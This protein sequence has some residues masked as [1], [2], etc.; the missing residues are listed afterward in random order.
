MARRERMERERERGRERDHQVN[1]NSF[2]AFW[3]LEESK[4]HGQLHELDLSQH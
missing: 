1:K 2:C 3:T 4:K